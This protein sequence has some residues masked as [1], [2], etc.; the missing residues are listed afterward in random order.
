MASK[1]EQLPDEQI[2]K[3]MK[4]V[5]SVIKDDEFPDPEDFYQYD[6]LSQ[7][8]SPMGG[9]YNR[10][11]I[12]YVYY[13]LSNNEREHLLAPGTDIDRPELEEMDVTF[14]LEERQYVTTS[15]YGSIDTYIYS[16]I[17]ESY[18]YELKDNAEIDPY[19]WSSDTEISDSDY[20]DDNWD[21]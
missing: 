13:L 10:L 2:K 17:T 15:Y 20:L 5:F 4:F 16:D 9:N 19:D 12:E 8:F 21:Y 1:L 18:L 14:N 6:K 3:Y 11:D 7:L